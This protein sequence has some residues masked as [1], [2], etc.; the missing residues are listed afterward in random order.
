MKILLT[1]ANGQVGYEL[2]RTL[3]HFGEVIP[4]TRKGI[5]VNGIPTLAVDLGDKD[6]IQKKLAT[7]QPD[8]IVNAAAYTAV[9]K[10]EEY[11]G[12]A[13]SI[14]ANAPS[15]FS[16][17][18]LK[19]DI[20]LTHYSTDYVFSGQDHTPWTEQNE[21]KP[22]SV[23]GESKLIGEHAIE[24]SGCKHMIFRTAWV[25]SSRGHNFLKSMLRLA[26]TK[27]ELNIVND[28]FGSP[29]WAKSLAVATA[30]TLHQPKTGTYHMTSSGKTTWCGFAR[31]IFEQ[32]VKLKLIESSP[33]VNAIASDQYP[34]PA[35][36]PA[37]SVLDCSKLNDT[38]NIEMPS[39]QTAL[40]LCMQEMRKED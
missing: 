22:Q 21:T 11:N 29:T 20:Y 30:L 3:Q 26:E 7:I 39:W 34:T 36:R 37:Y 12:E 14:N 1:G 33:I 10:A 32:A 28:Q 5:Q 2:W 18:A 23:Y 25:F 17:Y 35:K 13:M 15:I 16:E 40:Q 38:F 31:K 27:S 8:H 24:E 9:D 19:N 4:T 6:D